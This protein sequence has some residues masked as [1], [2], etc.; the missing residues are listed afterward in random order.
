MPNVFVVFEMLH[1]VFEANV[2]FAE[3]VG[4]YPSLRMS[5]RS[6]T[7]EMVAKQLHKPARI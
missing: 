3:N 6:E 2:L 4:Y 5:L 1:V 7:L